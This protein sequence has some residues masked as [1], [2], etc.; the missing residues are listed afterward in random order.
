M[1]IEFIAYLKLFLY[2]TITIVQKKSHITPTPKPPKQIQKHRSYCS[3]MK[4]DIPDS[5]PKLIDSNTGYYLYSTLK[6]C[7]ENRVMLYSK[8]FNSI[9]V[10]VFIIVAAIILYICFHRKKTNQEIQNDMMRDQRIILEKI[11][12]LQLQKQNYY[13]ESSMTHLPITGNTI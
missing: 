1:D 3:I 10:I 9:I 5:I 12:S 7:H 11:K 13:E 2:Y 4:F 6:Q 8:I